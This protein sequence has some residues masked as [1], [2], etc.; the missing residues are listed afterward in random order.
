MKF[1]NNVNELM[2]KVLNKSNAKNGYASQLD[3]EAP[4]ELARTYCTLLFVSSTDYT[5]EECELA[6][7]TLNEIEAA[8]E[9]TLEDAKFLK[10]H[11]GNNPKMVYWNNLIAE[12]ENK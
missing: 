9:F 10:K 5:K 8:R 1:N 2:K 7:N 3:K 4:S 12:L 11:N 6:L